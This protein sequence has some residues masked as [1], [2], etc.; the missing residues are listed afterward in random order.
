MGD[1]EK[2]TKPLRDAIDHELADERE[3]AMQDAIS[4]YDPD[5]GGGDQDAGRETNVSAGAAGRG[6]GRMD[7]L[8][9]CT[10]PIEDVRR[11][12]G[13][14]SSSKKTSWRNSIHIK[15]EPLPTV[16]AAVDGDDQAPATYV[17]AG[18]NYQK[19]EKEITPG[20]PGILGRQRT[21]DCAAGDRPESTGRRSA[22]AEWLSAAD[23]PLTARVMV[24][25]LWQYHFGQGIVATPNDFGMMG[26]NPTPSGIARLAVVGIGRQR[27]ALESDS[28]ADRDY[29]PRIASRRRWIRLRN[30][31]GRRD[32]GRSE[33]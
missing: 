16:M 18:G 13:S 26:G 12:S 33:Q 23:H 15:P 5:D 27:L 21:G 29:R 1:W 11:K 32:R 28:A 7:R 19:P 20:F 4:A 14:W 10:A 8:C 22:L 2:A 3:A 24:N 30:R 25:R 9:D 31:T 17:L 6:S